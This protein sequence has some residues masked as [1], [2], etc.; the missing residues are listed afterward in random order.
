MIPKEMGSLTNCK[1][2]L[3]S[4]FVMLFG[5]GS[6]K[7]PSTANIVTSVDQRVAFPPSSASEVRCGDRFLRSGAARSLDLS[8]LEHRGS[9]RVS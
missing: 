2:H 3:D 7:V 1:T 4:E 6:G 5:S 8:Q 9:D